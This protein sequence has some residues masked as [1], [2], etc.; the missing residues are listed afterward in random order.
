MSTET[1]V[2]L[3]D[4]VNNLPDQIDDLIQL[5]IEAIHKFSDIITVSPGLAISIAEWI[6]SLDEDL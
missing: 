2:R 3:E 5:I 6:G 4:C 1:G